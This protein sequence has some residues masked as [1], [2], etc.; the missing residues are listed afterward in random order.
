MAVDA[1]GNVYTTDVDNAKRVQK[2]VHQGAVPRQVDAPA[3]SRRLAAMD[4][5]VSRPVGEK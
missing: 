5:A 3:R 2:L 1:R 4:A